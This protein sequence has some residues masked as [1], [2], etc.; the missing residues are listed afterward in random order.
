MSTFQG[1]V[2]LIP[3]ALTTEDTNNDKDE[4]ESDDDLTTS[5]ET[6]AESAGSAPT[7]KEPVKQ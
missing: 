3:V 5:E 6:S 7:D 4:A 2:N 1:K